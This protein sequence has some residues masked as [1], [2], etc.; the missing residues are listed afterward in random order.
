EHH[1][2]AVALAR[3]KDVDRFAGLVAVAAIEVAGHRRAG[4][5][6]RL[7]PARQVLRMVLDQDAVVVLARKERGVVHPR[8]SRQMPSASCA[9]RS[10]NEN[11]THSGSPSRRSGCHDGTTNVSF[12]SKSKT[13]SPIRARPLPSTTEYTVASV[14]RLASPRKPAG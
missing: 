8:L 7:R 3:R 13:A 10:E 11:S 12:G 14:E 9:G 5:R 4:A 6:R 1:A 2:A